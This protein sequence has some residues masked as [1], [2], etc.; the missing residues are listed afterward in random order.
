[1]DVAAGSKEDGAN[2]LQWDCHDGSNQKM[3]F[4]PVAGKP[5]VYTIKF[6]HSSKC[7]NVVG[8]DSDGANVSQYTCNGEAN[9]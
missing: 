5:D 9:Q 1:M 3:T 2:V 7:L 4:T 8:D 6:E